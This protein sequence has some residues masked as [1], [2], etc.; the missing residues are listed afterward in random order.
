MRLV[1]DWS[2]EMIKYVAKF[3]QYLTL[4]VAKQQL[5]SSHVML[6]W[7]TL[8]SLLQVRGKG[9]YNIKF[10]LEIGDSLEHKRVLP[11]KYTR[12]HFLGRN[13]SQTATMLKG[14]HMDSRLLTNPFWAL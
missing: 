11:C 3:S 10:A 4:I 5:C 9:K 12:N 7:H 1:L 8:Y 13:S 6:M 14:D 2:A